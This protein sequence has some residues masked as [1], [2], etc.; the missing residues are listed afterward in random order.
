M[1]KELLADGFEIAT[2][3][4]LTDADI[5]TAAFHLEVPDTGGNFAFRKPGVFTI[6]LT[7]SFGDFK[8]DEAEI[9]A[10]VGGAPQIRGK[11][12][13]QWIVAA[14]F[15]VIAGRI[16]GVGVLSRAE[17]HS[18]AFIGVLVMDDGTI[19]AV[20]PVHEHV[21]AI[22]I[23]AGLLEALKNAGRLSTSQVAWA[24][25]DLQGTTSE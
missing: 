16:D 15:D 7:R 9:T 17:I 2:L 1:I 3:R 4:P 8:S 10:L 19:D 22:A 5:T 23:G 11:R 18:A 14:P 25:E 6:R 12:F 21:K 24:L 13:S 20:A